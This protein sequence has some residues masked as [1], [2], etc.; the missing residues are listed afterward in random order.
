MDK[1]EKASKQ[2][3][4]RAARGGGRALPIRRNRG[5][6]SGLRSDRAEPGVSPQGLRTP[7]RRHRMDGPA[8]LSEPGCVRVEMLLLRQPQRA[9]HGREVRD[10][11]S[12]PLRQHL[13]RNRKVHQAE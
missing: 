2:D 8:D 3:R 1:D 9:H 7:R 13:R 10:E 6:R 5:T 12:A 4:T 11:C